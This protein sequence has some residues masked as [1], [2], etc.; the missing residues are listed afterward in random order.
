MLNKTKVPMVYIDLDGVLVDMISEIERIF[1]TSLT[2][3]PVLGEFQISKASNLLEKDLQVVFSEVEFWRNLKPY[4]YAFELVKFIEDKVGKENTY[5]LTAPCLNGNC[6][7]GKFEWVEEYFPEFIK[8]KRLIIA[9]AKHTTA[10]YRSCLIDDN[11]RNIDEYNKYGGKGIL[12]P[13][14]WNSA[15]SL[16][17]MSIEVVKNDFLTWYKGFLN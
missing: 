17:E 9:S 12:V 10:S 6:Y 7:K 16:S 4:N 14:G 5:F 1:K 11:D 13:Q 8:Q 15:H 2:P 3:W